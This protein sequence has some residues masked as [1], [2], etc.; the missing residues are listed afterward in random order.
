MQNLGL[1]LLC[2]VV[3]GRGAWCV[4]TWVSRAVN[5]VDI[6]LLNFGMNG[7][8]RH[9]AIFGARFTWPTP[10]FDLGS[11]ERAIFNWC[12]NSS[13]AYFDASTNFLLQ[14]PSSHF[15]QLLGGQ[16]DLRLL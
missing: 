13:E 12:C 16:S 5:D 9:F 11:V 10:I 15:E 8:T 6:D 3:E 2:A 4:V 14:W 1:K 7:E